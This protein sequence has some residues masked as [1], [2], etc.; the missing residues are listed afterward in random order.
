M[1]KIRE[2]ARQYSSEYGG[3]DNLRD[4]VRQLYREYIKD[5][6]E[7]LSDAAA[8]AAGISGVLASEHF[9]PAHL[10]PQMREAFELAYPHVPIDT[11]SDYSHDQLEH[12]VSP[13]KGKLF[14][15]IVRDHLNNGD[16]VGDVHLDPGQIADLA[17]HAN[18][19]G[20]DLA[21]LNGDGS[22]ADQLQLKATTSLHY[23]KEA[24]ERY[25][26]I[27]ILST[28][29]AAHHGPDILHHVID[30]GISEDSLH[31]NV[32]SAMS[33][34]IDHTQ[35]LDWLHDLLP[36][37]PFV[38]IIG[39]E[40]RRVFIGKKSFEQAMAS[41]LERSIVS[42][43]AM[44][45]GALI[46]ALDGGIISI[47][48]TIGTR[49]VLGRFFNFRR[50]EATLMRKVEMVRVIAAAQGA[51]SKYLLPG[52]STDIVGFHPAGSYTSA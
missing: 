47:P 41:V 24:L 2:L 34:L 17:E 35:H 22:I 36:A 51:R 6:E 27:D 39:T 46:H 16:W 9:D 49:I 43:A 37:L 8:A 50:V 21:I 25:P 32:D 3:G 40:G 29:E 4:R 13:W 26:D 12:F 23:V 5:R 31:H 20:W 18:Q 11:L 45:V 10:S 38:I 42:G 33:P 52:P 7:S 28:E 48:A 14:E 44:S 1:D 15:V 19:P 30:S